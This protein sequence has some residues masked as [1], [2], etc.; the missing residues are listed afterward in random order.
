M[1]ASAVIKE[2]NRAFTSKTSSLEDSALTKGSILEGAATSVRDS[3]HDW[4]NLK[5]D[6]NHFMALTDL[7]WYDGAHLRVP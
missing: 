3:V 4:F 1:D 7:K 6:M 5:A 2:G